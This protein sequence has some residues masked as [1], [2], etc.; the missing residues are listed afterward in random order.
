M[1]HLI[2]VS[3]PY[4]LRSILDVQHNL[5]PWLCGNPRYP[6]RFEKDGPDQG[7]KTLTYFRRWQLGSDQRCAQ[8]YLSQVA[9]WGD[10]WSHDVIVRHPSITLTRMGVCLCFPF[11]LAATFVSDCVATARPMN[12]YS[13]VSTH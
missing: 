8:G 1:L 9:N 2:L 3:S 10:T 4:C 7:L 13:L 11:S 5:F 6:L 12:S